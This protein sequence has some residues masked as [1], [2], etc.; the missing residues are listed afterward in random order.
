MP[1][2]DLSRRGF[3]VAGATVAMSAGLATEDHPAAAAA[4]AWGGSDPQLHLLRRATYGP[5]PQALAEIRAMGTA[6]WLDRQLRPSLIDDR[7]CDA[8]VARFPGLGWSIPQVR[9]S[10][11]AGQRWTMMNRLT[12]ATITR[13]A[14]SRRQL[15]EVMVDFWSNHLNVTCPASD[16][17]DS[18]AHYDTVLRRHALGRYRDLLPAAVTHPAMLRYLDNATSTAAAPNENLGR[19]LLELHTVGVEAGYT[20]ADV[21]ASALAL[22]GLTTDRDTGAYRFEPRWRH[23]GPVRVLGF[24]AAN[25]SVAAA[26]AVVSAYLR[27]LASHPATARRLATKLAVRFVADVPPAA[28]VDRLAAVYLANDTAI[29]PVLRALFTSPEFAAARHAKVKRPYEDLISTIRILGLRPDRSGTAGID[30]LASVSTLLGQRP[31]A[32]HPPDG[33][34]DQAAAWQSPGGLLGRWNMHLALSAGWW[35]TGLQVPPARRLLPARLPRT[36]GALVDQLCQRLVFRAPVRAH[37]D[38]LLAFLGRAAGDPV[39]ETDRALAPSRLPHLVALV[40]DSPYF[41]VR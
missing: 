29:A 26:P 12:S 30:A 7:A 22:T 31:L 3:L 25:D 24:S 6:R 27:Y 32:W 4:V 35:A 13:A 17:W 10:F 14:W 5:T 28:L 18:R 8:V 9:G 41:Q 20:E 38:A 2:T 11:G 33:Y 16:V 23:V 21:R 37:R 36:Y 40:L 39:L 1:S 34:P 15:L 19:E